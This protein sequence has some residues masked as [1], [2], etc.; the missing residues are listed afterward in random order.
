M[1][2]GREFITGK[3]IDK[4]TRDPLPAYVSVKGSEPGTSADYNGTF[5]LELGS[6]LSENEVILEVFQVG[7]KRK[8]VAARSGVEILIEM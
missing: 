3:I 4:E 7:Y 6:V 2:E 1:A 8:E 5:K